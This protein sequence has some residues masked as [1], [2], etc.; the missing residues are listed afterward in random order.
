MRLK[1]ITLSG[2]R[3]FAK[4]ESID[5]DADAVIVS[6]ANGRGKTSMFDAILWA[7]TGS[8]ERLHGDAGDIVSRYS[9][10]GEARVELNLDDAGASVR[11]IRRFDGEA[12]LSLETSNETVRGASAQ[13]ALIDL[14]WPEAR[15]ASEPDDALSRSLTRAMYLQ[16]DV[17][18]EFVEADDEQQRFSVVSEL[19]GVGRVTELQRQLETSRTAWTRA[20]N[21]IDDDLKP[22]RNQIMAL[23]D[24]LRRLGEGDTPAFDQRGF[25]AWVEEAQRLGADIGD[26]RSTGIPAVEPVLAAL[27]ATQLSNDRAI[28]SLQRLRAHLITEVPE[29]IA[30]EPLRAQVHASEAIVAEAST[31]L[32]IAQESVAAELR[33]QAEVRDQAESL[34]ALA[35]LALRH[36]GERC[37]VCDQTYDQEATRARLQLQIGGQGDLETAPPSPSVEIA[38]VQLEAAQR[39]LAAEE[40]ALRAAERSET[41]RANWDE[42]RDALAREAGL[43]ASTSL[44]AD[45]EE[46]L[47]S[48]QEADA[49]LRNLRGLGEQY[50]LQIARLAEQNQRAEVDNQL[51]TLREDLA[52]RELEHDARVVTGELANTL[53]AGL[54]SASTRIVTEELDRIGPLLQRIYASVEPHP[55]FRAVRF[56]TSISR[57]HGRVWT[58]VVDEA[59]QKVVNEPSVV[60]SSS[61]LNVLAVSTFLSLNLAIESLPLQV[62]A[63]DDPLQ[64]LDTVN[65]LGLADLIRRVR[66][67]RQVLVSTHDERLADLLSRK[68]RPVA[69][70]ERTRVVKFDAWTREGPIVEQYDVPLDATPL[71]LVAAG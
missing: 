43:A 63:M 14:L 32:Q 62:V 57:G 70:G 42:T 18:R 29:A 44:P 12:H 49:R 8:V 59:A 64:S 5:L 71:K 11:V 28:S 2:F 26:I 35:Q 27:Q 54:R 47:T 33:R 22:L 51:R 68:L 46:A 34:R 16:Q 17:V 45:V 6:G 1:S 38:A 48:R 10:S 31:Q 20:T 9:P 61:Q 24:R 52:G 37:P 67:S 3:G 13:T 50:S 56:L 65:L 60:L 30:A 15:A 21:R 23:E 69:S 58:T 39:Q 40:A 7:L 36:L 25:D 66:A 19:V 55:S 41:L 53:L 4:M